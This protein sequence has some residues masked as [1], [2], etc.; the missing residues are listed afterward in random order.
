MTANNISEKR[1]WW[2]PD[3]GDI[4]RDH[5]ESETLVVPSLLSARNICLNVDHMKKPA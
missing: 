1:I 2:R 3:I 5:E 4:E